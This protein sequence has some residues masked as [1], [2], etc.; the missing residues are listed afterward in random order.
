MTVVYLSDRRPQKA[1]AQPVPVGDFLQDLSKKAREL[2]EDWLFKM[3]SPET[4]R[5]MLAER[6]IVLTA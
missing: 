1:P 6:G 4:K 3:A 2:S 5:A